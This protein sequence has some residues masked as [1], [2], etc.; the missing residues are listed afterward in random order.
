MP[1]SAL[2]LTHCPRSIAFLHGTR[3]A[4]GPKKLS[5]AKQPAVF[6]GQRRETK[7]FEGEYKFDATKNIMTIL[8]ESKVLVLLPGL[9]GVL[10]VAQYY[11]L[12]PPIMET[13]TFTARKERRIGGR[14]D[15]RNPQ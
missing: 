2:A 10:A 13:W 12:V 11:A 15:Q 14:G 6:P 8:N 1:P 3:I 7:K 5:Q 9:W 4:A